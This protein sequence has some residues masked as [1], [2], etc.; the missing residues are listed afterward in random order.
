MAKRYQREIEEILKQV[1]DTGSG[2]KGSSESDGGKGKPPSRR[3][4]RN[5][6]QLASRRRSIR[7]PSPG[8][9]LLGGIALF[10]AAFVLRSAIPGV[11]GPMVW[12][13]ICLFIVSYIAFFTRSQ[14]PDETRWRGRSI[15]DEPQHP[16]LKDRIIT[17]LRGR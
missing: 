2:G 11:F 10:V 4:Q 9:F 13:G 3:P 6:E 17:W 5:E 12:V 15:E 16:N 8:Q 14:R 1:N 7:A